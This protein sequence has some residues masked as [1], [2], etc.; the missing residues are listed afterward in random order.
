MK[1]FW[2]HLES[3]SLRSTQANLFWSSGSWVAWCFPNDGLNWIFF[4]FE[5]IVSML[6]IIPHEMCVDCMVLYLA[7]LTQSVLAGHFTTLVDLRNLLTLFK[8]SMRS[9]ERLVN[10]FR[11]AFQRQMWLLVKCEDCLYYT[12]AKIV[13]LVPKWPVYWN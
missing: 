6:C 10:K 1:Q 9:V 12:F 11:F 13:T 4:S 2:L 7:S 8:S 5:S 3:S